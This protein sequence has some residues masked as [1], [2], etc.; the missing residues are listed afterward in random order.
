MKSNNKQNKLHYKMYKSGKKWIIAGIFT[1]TA[2]TSIMLTNDMVNAD[3]VAATQSNATIGGSNANLP[4]SSE[5]SSATS[6]VLATSSQSATY[7]TTS[8]SNM[9]KSVNSNDSSIGNRG[10]TSDNL[11]RNSSS[12]NTSNVTVSKADSTN[13]ISSND[14]SS[15]KASESGS[16]N[17]VV[18]SSKTNDSASISNDTVNSNKS[19]QSINQ[20]SGNSSVVNSNTTKLNDTNNSVASSAKSTSSDAS[21]PESLMTNTVLDQNFHYNSPRGYSNDVQTI[22]PHKDSNGQID[23][24]DVYYLYNPDPN[25][26]G[27]ADEWYHAR[28]SDF[29]TFTPYDQSNPTSVSNV[30]IPD[31]DYKDSNGNSTQIASS[32]KNGI[33]WGYAATGSVIYN[34][35]MLSKD[36]W[37]NN[38]DKDAKL[39]YFT[40]LN[41][42]GQTIFLA[43]SNNDQQFHP[44]SNSPVIS[45]KELGIAER[46]GEFRDISVDRLSDNSL[47]GYVAG[48]YTSKMYVVTSKDGVNWSYNPSNDITLGQDGVVEVETPIVKYV[49]GQ[50]FLFYSWHEGDNRANAAI[51]GVIGSDG[52]FKTT[53]DSKSISVDGVPYKGDTYAGN[54]TNVDNDTLVNINWSGN[55]NYS[56]LGVGDSYN[57]LTMHSG[58]FALPRLV[59]NNNGQ[60]QY[61][62]IE[63][64]NEFIGS[65]K[66]SGSG[67]DFPILVNTNNKFDFSFG[68]PNSSK[69][70][71]LKRNNSNIN[72]S[73]DNGKITVNR[74][75]SIN[76]KF[77]KSITSPFG[78]DDVSKL[79]LYVDNASIELYLPE[80]NQ[81]YNIVNFST[82]QNEPYKM[83][84]NTNAT[85]DNYEFNSSY[86]QLSKTQIDTVINN[87]NSNI[88][89]DGN[90]SNS[91]SSI[92]SSYA[93]SSPQDSDYSRLSSMLSSA[94]NNLKSANTAISTANSYASVASSMSGD[95]RSTL[96]LT[97]ASSAYLDASNAENYS[98]KSIISARNTLATK[99]PSASELV[100]GKQVINGH[101]V[102]FIDG[103][104]VSGEIYTDSDGQ[105]HYYDSINGYEGI[106][107]FYLYNGKYYYFDSNGNMVKNKFVDAI[108]NTDYNYY[109][110]NDGAAVDGNQTIDGK[111]YL[112]NDGIQVKNNMIINPDSTFSY[113]DNNGLVTTTPTNIN[114]Q[115]FNF[116]SDGKLVAP[117]QFI[118]NSIFS[119][120]TYYLDSNSHISKG[121]QDIN[122]SKYYFDNNGQM[123]TN[124]YEMDSNGNFYRFG[125][126]GKAL[127]G[128]QIVDYTKRYFNS[129]GVQVKNSAIIDGDGKIS[130]YDASDGNPI[131]KVNDETGKN[132]SSDSNDNIV[133]PDTFVV[134]PLNNNLIYY[135]NSDNKV[136]KGFSKIDGNRYY[137]DN[138]GIML[139][140]GTINDSDGNNY[141]ANSNGILILQNASSSS[142]RTVSSASSSLSNTASSASSSSNSAVSSASSSLSNTASSSSSMSNSVF[143]SSSSN[144][145][146]STNTGTSTTPSISTGGYVATT[147]TT[148]NAS[149]SSITNFSSASSSA[150]S[151]SVSLAYNA[152]SAS[153]ASSSVLSS[154]TSSAKSSEPGNDTHKPNDD[155][156]TIARV[157]MSKAQKAVKVAEKNKQQS[158][159]NV[160]VKNYNMAVAN[161]YQAEKAYLKVAKLYN[162]RYYYD[163]DH[164]TKHSKNV[165]LKKLAFVYDSKNF[166]KKNRVH[167]LKKG[168]KVKVNKIVRHGKTTLFN[169]GHDK[170]IT[171]L[172]SFIHKLTK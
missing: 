56:P 150:T 135:L 13:T 95:I 49:N 20:S 166:A 84:V 162:S 164:V 89:N 104:Q 117:N 73:I 65:Y 33:P 92:V 159:S 85:I 47:V 59:K 126:D 23:Y 45:G 109:F 153:S 48:A 19:S 2:G 108:P 168:T 32:N 26:I 137:F 140:N 29:K 83:T 68:D 24:Y 79:E 17:G 93:A 114:N 139:K 14:S 34:N 16:N 167:K 160:H 171:G 151:S 3:T 27:F 66:F 136:T 144:K 149:S 60:L 78:V 80:N 82:K 129:D 161:Y 133:A 62:P 46:P 22:L 145:I 155:A 74:D 4:Q 54:Y 123:I 98:M 75:N 132:V 64:N 127:I 9:N 52:I 51:N 15:N 67:N 81:T 21:T 99:A 42:N 50:A 101:N 71:T 12:E 28:T 112:F 100:N 152:S 38:I 118:K 131:D 106:N 134:S 77:S 1:I 44:Y 61:V 143:L 37:N 63:P 41:P 165:K 122:G 94:D 90:L 141:Q 72:I 39:A 18:N 110:G 125:G 57:Y 7:S 138:N 107:L 36:Q 87:L 76:S 172:K 43:Y 25:Q 115:N 10:L 105:S 40:D 111:N 86:P 157:A 30:A 146:I 6:V 121:F 102:M 120:A 31:P 11:N 70:I 96:Y 142:N 170:F 119:N 154:S 158:H 148:I 8:S 91:L 130:F 69:S 55:W 113:Y 88:S 35:G 97:L 156:I 169:I 116:N 53:N 5:A 128:K 58:S 124:T 103:K 147:N 163:F